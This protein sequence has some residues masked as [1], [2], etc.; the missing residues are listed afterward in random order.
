MTIEP[1]VSIG[2][3]VYNSDDTI[4][5][6]LRSVLNQ[7]YRNIEVVVSDNCSTDT[8]ASICKDFADLDSRISLVVQ[9]ENIGPAANF[10]FVLSRATGSYF[11]WVAAD[12]IKSED[13]VSLNLEFLEGNPDFLASTC[14]N[15]FDAPEG[16]THNWEMLAL[17]GGQKSRI[18]EFLDNA[19]RSHG[20][21]YSLFRTETLKGYPW[22]GINFLAWD[23]LLLFHFS[24]NWR[25]NR[26][27]TGSLVLG[28][29]G[30]STE[31]NALELSGV[32]GIRRIWPL[33]KFSLLASLLVIQNCPRYTI[34][35]ITKVLPLNYSIFKHQFFVMK[36][37]LKYFGSRFS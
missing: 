11:M 29:K 10:D 13:F 35:T 23:W 1:L 8:T 21:F 12:D 24:L 18:S 19:E 16:K 28:T 15:R 32:T 5:A 33:Y 7:S 34:L 20:L 3:P 22:F 36:H 37:K 30:Q 14:P 25:F 27:S 6:C 2:I 31:V 4:A 9:G 17:N 26:T